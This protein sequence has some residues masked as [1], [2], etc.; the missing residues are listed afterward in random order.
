MNLRRHLIETATLVAVSVVVALVSNAIASKERKLKLPGDY[1]NA[2]SVPGPAAAGVPSAPVQADS[3]TVVS[4]Y[5][6]VRNRRY[7]FEG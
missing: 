6:A 5:S 1:P 2:T 3:S 7:C 4:C